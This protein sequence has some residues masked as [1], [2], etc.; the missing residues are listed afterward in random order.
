MGVKFAYLAASIAVLAGIAACATNPFSEPRARWRAEVEEACLARGY[1][2]PSEYVQAMPRLGGRGSCGLEHPFK[3]SA[4]SRG[5]VAIEPAAT[6]NCPMISTIDRWMATSV[7]PAAQTY[8]GSRVVAI[9]Q[10]ASYGCRTRENA[11]GARLSEHA[12]ANALDVAGFRLADGRDLT[13]GG[14]WWGGPPQQRAFLQTIFAGACREFH[15]VLGP[16]YNRAHANHFHI[17][18]LKTNGNGGR[19]VCR[20]E[21]SLGSVPM[22]A[23]PSGGVVPYSV[24]SVAKAPL[25]PFAS[26]EAD[27]EEGF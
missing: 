6:L 18:L 20:P 11:R 9:R 22:A 21:P 13:I 23:K 5:S 25:I 14:G 10:I 4:A 7:Q 12:F 3:V 8:F 2:K 15:T 1:V 16:G 24:G 26:K 17:D 19:H 27:G